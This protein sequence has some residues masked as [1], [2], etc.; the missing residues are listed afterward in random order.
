M[1]CGNNRRNLDVLSGKKV[2]GDRYSCLKRGIGIGLNL[3]Y[4]PSFATRYVP[5]DKRKI[6][7]GKDEKMPLGYDLVGNNHMCFSKGVGVGRSMKAK[8]HRK[9]TPKKAKKK[10]KPSEKPKKKDKYKKSK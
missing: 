7:C 3:P 10:S 1:Y 9:N 4:D 6:Y 8:K 5:I 2:I